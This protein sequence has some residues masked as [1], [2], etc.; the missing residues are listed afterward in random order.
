M[1]YRTFGKTGWHV[2]EIGLGG[3]W[4]YGR[5]EEGLL[6]PEHGIALV[7]RALELGINYFDTAPLYGRGRSEEILGM[8]LREVERAGLATED[9]EATER[10]SEEE[11]NEKE[12]LSPSPIRK[13]SPSE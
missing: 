5:P 3:S 9:T 4:F 10:G 7:R 13:A 2:S 12:R 1:N 8:A 6:P 11:S